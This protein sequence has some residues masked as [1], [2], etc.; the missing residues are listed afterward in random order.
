MASYR[1]IAYDSA[2]HRQSRTVS[3]QSPAQ[4]KALL[5][6]QDLVIVDIRARLR[7]PTLEELFPSVIRVR[8]PEVI[9]FTRQ[10]AT[11]VHVGMPMMEGLAVLR[12]QAV[13][14]GMTTL[15][16]DAVDKVAANQ[17]TLAEVIRCVWIN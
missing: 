13:R 14:E 6:D 8:R 11:F 1:Y 9:L 12:D 17:T 10:L 15:R 4:V 7:M 5:W 16:K 2:G 3:A